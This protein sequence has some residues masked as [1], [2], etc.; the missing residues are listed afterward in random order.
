MLE[1]ARKM[2]ATTAST[3]AQQLLLRD[4]SAHPLVHPCQSR[5]QVGAVKQ[6]LAH[7]QAQYLPA[8]PAT[9]V[10][11]AAVG[12]RHAAQAAGSSRYDQALAINALGGHDTTVW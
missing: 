5:R 9:A 1:A 4:G 8:V 2:W 6:H 7:L 10:L 3:I 12:G 11:V